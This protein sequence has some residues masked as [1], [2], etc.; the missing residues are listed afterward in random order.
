MQIIFLKRVLCILFLAV[1]LLFHT[2]RVLLYLECEVSNTISAASCDCAKILA[3]TGAEDTTI[4]MN[5]HAGHK[6]LPEEFDQAPAAAT[7]IAALQA[8]V[9]H[10][11]YAGL[12]PCGYHP[13]TFHPPLMA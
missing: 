10:T 9:R 12:L 1:F 11:A 3:G 8:N 7:L 13:E 4:P 5:T 2:G 6:H